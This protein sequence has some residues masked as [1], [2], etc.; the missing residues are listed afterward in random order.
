MMKH[1]SPKE[2]EFKWQARSKKDFERFRHH[3][4]ALGAKAARSQTVL[5]R[6]LYLDTRDGKFTKAGLKCRLRQYGSKWQLTLK[7]F[8]RRKKGL[9]QRME[10]EIKLPSFKYRAAALR[11]VIDRL[12]TIF[13][14]APPQKLFEIRNLRTLCRYKLPGHAKA[15]ACFDRVTISKGKKQ[16]KMKEIEFEFL[17]GDL[18]AFKQFTGAL[19]LTSGLSPQKKSKV[20]TAISTFGLASLRKSARISSGRRFAEYSKRLSALL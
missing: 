9:V 1:N 5:I 12:G 3:A 14:D 15:E 18:P 4:K 20:A 17:N 16:I 8:G 6:D 19:T 13:F 7:S 10:Q 2:I 11:Y